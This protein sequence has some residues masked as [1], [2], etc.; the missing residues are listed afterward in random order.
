MDVLKD[1]G[2]L[3]EAAETKSTNSITLYNYTNGLDYKKGFKRFL[4][5]TKMLV[6]RWD[7]VV[8]YW[9]MN[10]IQIIEVSSMFEEVNI[11]V[12]KNISIWGA[13]VIFTR[14]ISEGKTLAIADNYQECDYADYRH[15][16]LGLC[17]P[18]LIKRFNNLKAFW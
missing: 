17:D 9:V 7:L 2:I 14:D 6:D 12:N 8:D 3:L 11:T 13:N 10:P 4:I 1:L 18:E 5:E 16:A 15:V